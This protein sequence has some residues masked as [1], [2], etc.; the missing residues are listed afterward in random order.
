MTVPETYLKKILAQFPI[1]FKEHTFLF[2]SSDNSTLLLLIP[3]F[4]QNCFSHQVYEINSSVLCTS[5]KCQ[6]TSLFISCHEEVKILLYTKQVFHVQE[7]K[8]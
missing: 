8:K 5:L 2:D 7:K 4:L 6:P 1:N 3:S